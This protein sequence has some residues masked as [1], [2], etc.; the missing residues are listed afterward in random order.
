MPSLRVHASCTQPRGPGVFHPPHRQWHP[1]CTVSF[2]SEWSH[3]PG[4]AVTKM[5]VPLLCFCA[6]PGHF[7]SSRK[8]VNVVISVVLFFFFFSRALEKVL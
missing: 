4:R 5:A 1:R 8:Y 2:Y 6:T 3:G 7:L